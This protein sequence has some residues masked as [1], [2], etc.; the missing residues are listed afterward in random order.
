M[1][2]RIQTVYFLL[3]VILASV[4]FFLP[5]ATLH[6]QTNVLLYSLDYRGLMLNDGIESDIFISNN[7]STWTLKIISALIPLVALITIFLYKKRVLQIRLSFINMIIMLGYYII[8]F[9]NLWRASNSLEAEWSLNV[10]AAF[11]LICVILNWLAI[12]AIGKDE[13]L[14]KSLNRLR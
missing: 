7:V 6:D 13:A 9:L 14:V 12:R 1:I 5:V 3:I 8:L 11:P 4:A 10:V 2:Q